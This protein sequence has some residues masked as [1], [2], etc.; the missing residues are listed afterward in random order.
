M[1]FQ[2]CL[3]ISLRTYTKTCREVYSKALHQQKY[4]DISNAFDEKADICVQENEFSDKGFV[5]KMYT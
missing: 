1:Q 4:K 2:K 5:E 3:I